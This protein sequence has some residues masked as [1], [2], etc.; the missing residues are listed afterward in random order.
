MKQKQRRGNAVSEGTTGGKATQQ[1][2]QRSGSSNQKAS[3]PIDD[4]RHEGATRKNNPPAKLAAEGRLP[5]TP[6][7]TYSFNPRLDPLLRSDPSGSADHAASLTAAA[8]V[9]ALSNDEVAD[10]EKLLRKHEP[11][12]EWSGK[13]ETKGFAVDPVALHIHERISAQAILRV[14]GREDVVRDLFADPKLTYREAVKFYQHDVDWSNRLILGDSLQ[15]MASLAKREDLCG[16]VQMIYVDPPSG[17]KYSSNFQPK[18][19]DRAVTEKDKDLTR[20]LETVK[21][22]RDTW[23]L[24]LHSYLSYLRE[25]L[26]LCR[27]LLKDSGHV[28]VQISDDNLHVVRQLMD[29][30]FGRS[31][32]VAQISVQKTGSATGGFIQNNSDYLLWYCRDAEKGAGTFQKLYVTR[33]RN[34]KGG[35]AYN[36]VMERSGLRR[37]VVESD[38]DDNGELKE[39]LEFWQSYPLTSDGFRETTTVDFFYQ[40]RRFHPGQ[41]RHWGVRTEEL[42]RAAQA[43]RIIADGDQVRLVK[44]W[45]DSPMF[46]LGA[47]WNDVGGAANKVYVC[48]MTAKVIERCVLMTTKPGDLVLDPT[49]GG[50]TTA[51]V[52]EQWGRRWITMDTSRVAIAVTRQRLLTA[53]Y[54]YYRLKEA[55][56]GVAG[57]FVY[58]TVPNITL[59]SIAQNANLDP[60][61]RKYENVLNEN[62]NQLNSALASVDQS[63][64]EKLAEK[65]KAKQKQQ[66]KRSLTEADRRRWLLPSSEVAPVFWTGS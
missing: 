30:I 9:R 37:P 50:G 61:L 48:Q 54:D 41:N 59:K 38:F 63:L 20:E 39:G 31:N 10:L 12:L 55:S 36:R 1:A 47:N 22:F 52:A 29:E 58:K 6:P 46:V 62:L 19:G 60:I 28:F 33:E 45:S 26:V 5:P 32:H 16:K 11:W 18:V 42:D 64:R 15:V 13:R 3:L 56:T 24:G 2:R 40:N 49:C 17:I 34:G 44:L 43:D 35:A 65:Q 7:L 21:A 8:R 27:E 57:D 53:Q 23:R 4:Y 25:R 14:A 66:G 51:Y